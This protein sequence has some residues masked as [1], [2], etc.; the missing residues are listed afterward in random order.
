MTIKFS[1]TFIFLFFATIAQALTQGDIAA[2]HGIALCQ[3]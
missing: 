1:F 2:S 3:P